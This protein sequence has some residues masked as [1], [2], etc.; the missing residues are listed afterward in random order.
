MML[1]LRDYVNKNR[2]PGVVLGLS[3]GIDSALSAAVAVDALGG[4]RVRCVMLP[5]RYTSRESLEDADACARMLGVKYETIEIEHAVA[6][7]GETLAAPFAGTKSDTTEE[8]LQSRLRGVILMAISN[9]FGPMVLTTGN[10]SEMSVGYATLYGDMCGGYAVLKD[11]YKMT[12]FALS[13]WRNRTKPDNLLGPAGPVIPERVLTK[14]PSAELKA[15]QTDQ[16]TLPP[17]EVL[18]A[19][20]ECLVEKE[21]AVPEVVARGHDEATVRMVWRMLDRAEYK[22]R[23]A[24]PGV[25]LTR[26]AFGRDRRYPVTNAF[27]D[28]APAPGQV[29]EPGETPRAPAPSTT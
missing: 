23:Q 12:V 25:K 5:S 21:L 1:G 13:G 19:I 7:M 9:K 6:A 28:K 14:P 20:L 15:N 2:F 4:S 27:Q 29:Q 22:R 18:D 3:G 11:V 10:K 16:D 24:P 8:N 17:Y 26:R